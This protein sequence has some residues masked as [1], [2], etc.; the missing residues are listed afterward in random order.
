MTPTPAPE[1]PGSAGPAV[2]VICTVRNGARTIGAAI[3][4]IIAQDMPDWTMIIVDDGSIDETPS[5]LRRYQASEPRLWCIQCGRVGRGE[6]LRVAVDAAATEFVA[7]QD[8][9]DISHPSRLRL[10]VEMARSRVEFDVLCT[11]HVLV[12][13][14]GPAEWPDL[15][16]TP[17]Y[18]E[19]VTRT[20]A[21]RNPVI[22][23]SVLMRRA[24][25]RSVGGY[26]TSRQRQ[27]DYDLWVRMAARGSRLGKM[28]AALAAKRL[29]EAQSFERRQRLRFLVGSVSVQLRAI[30]ALRGGIGPLLSLPAR[31][32]WNLLPARARGKSSRNR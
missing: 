27:F 22:H 10:Q 1:L 18:V 26:D 5:I 30:R 11:G 31:L 6:A 32:A 16:S 28:D 25:L 24:A 17:I 3:D 19:D 20:L 29:H 21:T 13:G 9:D 4:S 7:I 15:I 12:R 8:G 23:S 2:S 14:Y